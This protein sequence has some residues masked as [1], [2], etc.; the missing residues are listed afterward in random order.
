MS[1]MD[2]LQK[3]LLAVLLFFAPFAFAGAEPWAFSVLQGGIFI[4]L[5]ALLFKRRNIVV[6]SLFKPILFTLGFLTTFALLQSVFPQTILDNPVWYPSTFMR[7]FTLEHASLFVTYL[8]LT[9]WVSQLAES[10]R[11]VHLFALV[12]TLCGLAV[13]LCALCFPDGEYIRLLAGRRGGIGPFLNRNHAGLFMAM[14]AVITLGYASV[15]FLDYGR[16]AAHGRKGQFYLRQGFF[17]LLFISLCAGSVFTRSRGGMLALSLGIF[18]YAFL[19]TGVIPHRLKT[20][21]KGV[22]VTFV[23]L[24]CFAGWVG[25]HTQE[26]NRFARRAGG[27]SEQTRIMLYRAALDMLKERPIWGIGIGALPVAV[28]PRLERPINQYVE[29]LHSDWLEILLGTGYVGFLPV[30]AGVCWFIWLA[31]KRLRR[32]ETRK[33][34][35]FASLLSALLVM[36]VGSTVDFDFFIPATAFLFFMILGMACSPS[37]HKDHTRLRTVS[38]VGCAAV[39]LILLASCWIPLQK[40]AAW[41]L[42]LFGR[43]LTSAPQIAAYEKA[44]SLYPAPRYALYL[45]NAYYNAALYA[46]EPQ[47]NALR[48]QAFVLAERY[49]QKY[50]QDKELSRLYWRSRG[51]N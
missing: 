41:R 31:F 40:S 23:C 2:A 13:L 27:T 17:I 8:A 19:C 11:T 4:C 30:L 15:S 20:R 5:L 34:W 50:P 28:A 14:C 43:G 1:V 26:I 35:L 36:A 21:L 6:T 51:N 33:K 7:L 38:P 9:L 39:T 29:R 18:C 49:L 12:I 44:L 46:P 48:A 10:S 3:I 32:L 16:F 47:K 24:L 25:T 45:G 22:A 42:H 37:Y